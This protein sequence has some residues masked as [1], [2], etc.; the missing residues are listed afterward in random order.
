MNCIG[1]RFRPLVVLLAKVSA[2]TKAYFVRKQDQ[3][4]EHCADENSVMRV[5]QSVH[6]ASATKLVS[7]LHFWFHMR[8]AIGVKSIY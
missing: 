6:D 2:E 1:V 5:K 8:K 7:E 3:G 4:K